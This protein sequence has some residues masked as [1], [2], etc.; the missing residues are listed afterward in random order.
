MS[1]FMFGL[2]VIT[3]M[4]SKFIKILKNYKSFIFR[5]LFYIE[6][7]NVHGVGNQSMYE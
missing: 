7:K 1:N 4:N 2:H 5:F 3:T 6:F